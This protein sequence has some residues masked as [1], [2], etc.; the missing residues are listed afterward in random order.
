MSYAQAIKIF[1]DALE[2]VDP[3]T[4]PGLFDLASGLRELTQAL[5]DDLSAQA[6]LLKEIENRQKKSR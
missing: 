6:R 4:D 3:V 1:E 5:R 2:R